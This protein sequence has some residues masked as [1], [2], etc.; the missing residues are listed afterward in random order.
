MCF[1]K[2]RKA[3]TIRSYIQTFMHGMLKEALKSLEYVAH[4]FPTFAGKGICPFLMPSA[5]SFKKLNQTLL[6]CL[7][8]HMN[9]WL[10]L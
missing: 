9:I 5:I 6:M 10:Y 2:I 4:C 1:H 7:L 8:F 3:Y